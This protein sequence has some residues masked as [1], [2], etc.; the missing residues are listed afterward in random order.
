[1]A[2]STANYPR[3]TVT[4]VSN[5]FDTDF[6]SDKLSRLNQKVFVSKDICILLRAKYRNRNRDITKKISYVLHEETYIIT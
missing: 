4:I 2:M 1:M 5:R 3:V 6:K